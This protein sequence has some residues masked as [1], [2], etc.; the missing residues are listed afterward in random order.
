MTHQEPWQLPDA[1]SAEWFSQNQSIT[2]DAQ[3]LESRLGHVRG[4]LEMQQ[5]YR[6]AISEVSTKLETLDA[7]FRVRY[8]HNPIHHI[9]SRLKSPQSI[10]AKL[11]SKGIELTV[12]NVRKQ[13]MD[14]AG[15]RVVCNYIEDIYDI[16]EMLEAQNDIT[17]IRRRDYIAHPKENGYRSLHLII[18]V[19]VFLSDRT[20]H[21]PVEVQIR[22]IAMDF[23]ATLEHELRYKASSEISDALRNRLTQCAQLSADLDLEMQAIRNQCISTD[24]GRRPLP[25]SSAEHPS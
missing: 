23:W 11:K 13:L 8:E 17:P 25:P 15:V 18:R 5:V 1:M 24:A 3:A 7:E 14:I 21:V 16:A 6:A 4:F 2:L 22:T 12:E 20:E 9:E 10:M 19:P